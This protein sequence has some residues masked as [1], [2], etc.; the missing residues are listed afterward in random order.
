MFIIGNKVKGGLYGSYPSL[1]D[2]DNNGDLKFTADFR[3]VYAGVLKDHLGADAQK[4][5]GGAFEPVALLTS[6]A[7]PHYHSARGRVRGRS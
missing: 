3:S 5:L 1:T 4:V 6:S 2:L 7:W